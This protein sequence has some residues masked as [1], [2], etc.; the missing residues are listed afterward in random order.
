MHATPMK[1][2]DILLLLKLLSLDR[3]QQGLSIEFKKPALQWLPPAPPLLMQERAPYQVTPVVAQPIPSMPDAAGQY[4]VRALA[5]ATGI[6]K[7]EV[8]QSL[9]RCYEARLARPDRKSGLPRAW[10]DALAEFILHGIRY[11]FPV[12]PAAITRG[13]PTAWAAP[14]MQGVLAG[15]TDL[16]PV[17]PDAMAEHSGEAITPLFKSAVF[18]ANADPTLYA[19]LALTDSIR[20]GLARERSLASNMLE[21]LLLEV[22]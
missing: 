13:L 12:K 20:I 14:I 7:S 18:A 21:K 2:Q 6:S 16:I 9:Q 3:Q 19:L 5:Q 17:W 4:S 15:A 8:S 11:V 22:Q 1:S 10:P